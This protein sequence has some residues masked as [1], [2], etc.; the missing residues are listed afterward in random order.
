M[1]KM[2]NRIIIILT[3]PKPKPNLLIF[4]KIAASINIKNLHLRITK[5]LKLMI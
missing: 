3:L 2:L 1:K 4:K 5:I